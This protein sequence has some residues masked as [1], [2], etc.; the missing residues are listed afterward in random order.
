MTVDAA[1]RMG[2]AAMTVDR[3][4][5]QPP[6]E[7]TFRVP[8]GVMQLAGLAAIGAGA[9]HAAAAGQHADNTA[10]ARLFVAVAA[11]QV[12]VGLLALVRGGRVAAAVTASVNAIAVGAWAA[13]RLWD[14]HWVSGLEQS[15]RPEFMDTACAALGA[16]AVI[17]AVAALVWRRTAVDTVRLGV[18]AMSVGVVALAAVLVGAG[19]THGVA[20]HAHDEAAADAVQVEPVTVVADPAVVAGGAAA[21]QAVGSDHDHAEPV[22]AEHDHAETATAGDAE[23]AAWPR[24]WDPSLPIDVSGVPGVTPEQEL[25]VAGLLKLTI[26]RLPQFA[27]AD[28]A[29]AAGFTSMG[30]GSSGHEH[31]INRGN[32]VDEFMLNPDHPESLVY[33]VDPAGERT[34]VGAMFM[35]SERPADDPELVNF[36]GPLLVWHDH[37]DLCYVDNDGGPRQIAGRMDA[38]GNCPEGSSPRTSQRPMVHVWIVPRECGPFAELQRPNPLTP[39]SESAADCSHHHGDADVASDSEATTAADADA[40]A[41]FDPTMPI[42]LSGTP[43]VTPQQQAFAENLVANTLVNLPQWSDPAVAEMFGFRSIGDG[44]TGH[45]HFVNWAWIN[46]TVYLD[47]LQ[48]ES[49]VYAT[50]ADGS[51]RLVAAMYMLPDSF[52]LDEVP[53]L[54]GDL[55]QWHI[56]DDLCFDVSDADAPVVA[57]LTDADGACA[58]PLVQL[59][60]SPMIHVWIA[61]HRCGPFAALEGIGGGQVAPGE[62]P[63]CGHDHDSAGSTGGGESSS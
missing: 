53:D 23:A 6:I 52:T 47:P 46:D 51:R 14:I 38:D 59:G 9:V 2:D 57:G 4:D 48:P 58:A 8:L 22:D 49:L 5:D 56:H 43:G 28:D 50:E 31:F 33:A 44:F 19:H 15:E 40:I 34:L 35:A 62:E 20:G 42:D 10:T 18:P 27:D 1:L 39:E 12:I 3:N 54:G 41:G 36:G 17:A 7:W 55:M 32:M 45:E 21:L 24:P 30:D 60:Q 11:A 61:P 37:Q 16:V 29:M 63:R 13:T 25:R 26:E